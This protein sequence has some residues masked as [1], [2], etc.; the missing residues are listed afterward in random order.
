M[1]ELGCV[2]VKAH[3]N[4]EMHELQDTKYL[5]TI[6]MIMGTLTTMNS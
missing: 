5:C 6:M 3:K 1:Q 4:S 2:E